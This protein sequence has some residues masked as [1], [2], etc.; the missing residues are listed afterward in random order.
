[1]PLDEAVKLSFES[2]MMPELMSSFSARI[3]PAELRI[4][5]YGSSSVTPLSV[6]VID[7][8]ADKVILN[9]SWSPMVSN[10]PFVVLPTVTVAVVE[11]LPGISAILLPV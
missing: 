5:R 7:W 3:V 9:Q 10:D 2:R 11:L 8:P 1:M 6:T 4:L